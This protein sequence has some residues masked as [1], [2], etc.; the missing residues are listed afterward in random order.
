MKTKM[1]FLSSILLFEITSAQI[2]I[3]TPNARGALDINKPTTNDHGLVLPTNSSTS[4]I[5]NPLG[6]EVAIGTIMYDSTE[7]CIKVYKSKGWSQCLGEGINQGFVL[8]CS[9]GT[10]TGTYTQSIP[11]SGTK[12]IN[13]TG[14]S[15]QSYN[16]I[17]VASTGVTGLTA[18]APVGALANGNGSITLNIS[19]TPS[20][21][22]T[23]NFTINIAGQTCT[24]IINIGQPQV[25]NVK[26]LSIIPDAWNSNLSNGR[27]TNI[28]RSKLNNSSNF[29]PSGKVKVTGFTYDTFNIYSNSAQELEYAIDNADIIWI[30]Y[31]SNSYFTPEKRQMLD[32]KIRE[33]KKF[34]F[35]GND[36]YNGGYF[37][38]K[39]SFAGHTFDYFRFGTISNNII[40]TTNGPDKG[41]FGN[42]S[43]GAPI[44]MYRAIGKVTNYPSGSTAFI[45]N[46][47]GTTN[48]VSSDNLVIVSDI[49]WYTNYERADG[50][51]G[52]SSSCSDNNNSILFCNI[53][54]KAVQYV[55]TH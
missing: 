21:S 6:G 44:K 48:A 18:S 46:T 23:A 34:F 49:N 35:I 31:I 16:A 22:G 4:K 9:S 17:S 3:G 2:G 25:R 39:T 1:L 14:A 27:Y 7:D 20:G 29:G 54:E 33:K 43:D 42:L 26:I 50:F 11:S 52:S 19:G 55:L 13:Y 8:D 45:R 24:F 12:T 41:I 28:A 37:P 10:L 40:S 51:Y 53:F 5:S 32:K 36:N 30:G 15:G 38:G 47:D